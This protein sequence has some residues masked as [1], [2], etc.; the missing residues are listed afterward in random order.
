MPEQDSKPPET[1]LKTIGQVAFEAWAD[2]L[3]V[4]LTWDDL[5][6]EERLAWEMAGEAAVEVA[7]G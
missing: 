6:E 2:A 5:P 7:K 1:V 4:S 3:N